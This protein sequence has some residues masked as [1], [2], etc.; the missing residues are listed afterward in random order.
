MSISVQK[1][2]RELED[3]DVAKAVG[4]DKSSA[5]VK[6]AD[7]LATP[8]T[9]LFQACMAQQTWTKLWKASNIVTIHIKHEQDIS[10]EI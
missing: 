1:V 5:L 9:A 2:K 7:Q 10:H 6:C 8:L 4:P 3:L